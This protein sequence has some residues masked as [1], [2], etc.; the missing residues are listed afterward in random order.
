MTAIAERISSESPT[1][2][3]KA[4]LAENQS[5]ILLNGCCGNHWIN[6]V[7]VR[8][9]DVGRESDAEMMVRFHLKV[10]P[11]TGN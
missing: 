7:M 5:G 9:L 1:E 11:I 8:E 3:K 10:K 6:K 2:D 4:R